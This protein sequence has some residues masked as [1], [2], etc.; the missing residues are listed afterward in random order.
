MSDPDMRIGIPSLGLELHPA[1]SNDHRL[2]Q[3]N[4]GQIWGR[5]H[6]RQA[7]EMGSAALAS[8]YCVSSYVSLS[9][10]IWPPV[11]TSYMSTCRNYY[12]LTRPLVMVGCAKS[13]LRAT[14]AKHNLQT[15]MEA[16]VRTSYINRYEFHRHK[17]EQA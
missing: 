16:L 15:I 8:A 3:H 1:I 7:D 6:W 5:Q 13:E 2:W 17:S 14:Q 9:I 4:Y 10:I 12:K 11:T